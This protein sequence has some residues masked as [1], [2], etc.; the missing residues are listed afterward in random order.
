MIPQPKKTVAIES[1]VKRMSEIGGDY[2]S[3]CWSF[4][5]STNS[6]ADKSILF[7]WAKIGSARGEY[8]ALNRYYSDVMKRFT[9]ALILGFDGPYSAVTVKGK[10]IWL[11]R[12]FGEFQLEG[13]DV[14]ESVPDSSV[15]RHVLSDANENS[16][17][18]RAT[19]EARSRTVKQLFKLKHVIGCG[20]LHAPLDDKSMH[21][22]LKAMPGLGYWEAPPEP[23]CVALIG[24]SIQFVTDFSQLVIDLHSS[25]ALAVEQALDSGLQGKKQIS[26][27]V[28]AI[29]Q[30]SDYQNLLSKIP[31]AHDWQPNHLS[32]ARLVRF[33]HAACLIIISFTCGAR[34]SEIRRAGSSSVQSRKHNDGTKHYYYFAA[35]SKVRFSAAS[36]K[37]SGTENISDPWILASAAV[38]AFEVLKGISAP[39]R[40]KSGIDNLWLTTYGNALWPHSPRNGF[41]VISAYR[42][43]AGMNDFAR[44][45][46][47]DEHE[48]WIGPLHSHMGRKNLARFMAKRDKSSLG[49]LARQYSHVSGESIDISYARPDSEFRRLVKDELDSELVGVAQDLLNVSTDNVYTKLGGADTRINRFIGELKASRDLKLLLSTGTK[50]VPCQWG[51]CLYQQQTSACAGTATNPN[52]A[53]RSPEICSACTNFIVSPKHALW[54]EE[55]MNDCQRVLKQSGLPI[56]IRS[57]MNDRRTVA[58]VIMNKIKSNRGQ[59]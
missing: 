16:K 42:M 7:D 15:T 51:Y 14:L 55:F 12:L 26:R 31:Q 2:N 8:Q 54:W 4:K 36:N 13:Y 27:H 24:A 59:P 49:D 52:P 48:Y 30:K 18:T 20:F 56:Q 10:V 43:N 3:D 17:L 32:V 1:L 38:Q 46:K 47:L 19:V 29:I 45:Y 23:F 9:A 33:L 21:K 35:R 6:V 39:A 37:S 57:L 34:I 11:R 44:F 28:A 40:K 41:I 58:E 22:V 50:L 25:Y 5:R 53:N